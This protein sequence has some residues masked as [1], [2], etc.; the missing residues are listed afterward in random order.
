MA[1]WVK[2]LLAKQET[3]ETQVWSLGREDPLEEGMATHSGILTWRVRWT[4]EP[5]ALQSMG[6]Q[7]VG[8]D[9]SELACMCLF[10]YSGWDRGRGDT[11]AE[12]QGSGGGDAWDLWERE[13]RGQPESAQLW[14]RSILRVPEKWEGVRMGGEKWQVG[15]RQGRVLGKE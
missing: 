9:W 5:C 3:P 6:L 8:H 2:N 10:K 14:G 12:A 11:W 7:R 1:Q 15:K 4:E 13:F